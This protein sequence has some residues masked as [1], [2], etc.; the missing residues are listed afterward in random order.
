MIPHRPMVPYWEN[1]TIHDPPAADF[2]CPHTE[3]QWSNPFGD[4]GDP[5]L[6][7]SGDIAR[8]GTIPAYV[9]FAVMNPANIDRVPQ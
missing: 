5:R 3:A 7:P 8:R 2:R 1:P 9:P 6:T 4:N